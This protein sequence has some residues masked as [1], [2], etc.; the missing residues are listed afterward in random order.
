MNAS[1]ETL[2]LGALIA[3]VVWMAAV[4]GSGGVTLLTLFYIVPG[5][6]LATNNGHTVSAALVWL[7]WLGPFGLLPLASRKVATS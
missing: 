5:I 2:S 1:Q 3:V 4:V 6:A 7:V